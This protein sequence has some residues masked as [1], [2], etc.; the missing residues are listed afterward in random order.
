MGPM[1]TKSMVKISINLN[2]MWSPFQD[3]SIAVNQAVH[4]NL[5][6]ITGQYNYLTGNC[7]ELWDIYSS[8][9]QRTGVDPLPIPFVALLKAIRL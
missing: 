9:H 5:F 2:A 6:K 7:I 3:I 4:R 1:V 8:H